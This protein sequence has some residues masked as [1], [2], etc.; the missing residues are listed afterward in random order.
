MSL[1]RARWDEAIC[2]D[3][4]ISWLR[5]SSPCLPCATSAARGRASACRFPTPTGAPAGAGTPTSRPCTRS[6]GKT[7]QAAERLHLLPEGRQGRP[8]PDCAAPTARRSVRSPAP[9]VIDRADPRPRANPA[10]MRT[11]DVLLRRPAPPPASD[12]PFASSARS[13]T[14]A[15]SRCRACVGCP[16]AA[17]A[18]PARSRPSVSRSTGVAVQMPA[19]HQHPSRPEVQQR[20]G[21]LA[22]SVGL[23]VHPRLPVSSS[24]LVEIGRDDRRQRQQPGDVS[25]PA[26]SGASRTSPCLLT[27]TGSTTNGTERRTGPPDLSARP[28]RGQ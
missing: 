19:L 27:P 13:P 1:V 17:H 3:R 26:A 7:P 15:C 9:P 20:L 24:H 5:E 18:A 23:T 12:R 14:P 11:C 2:T 28:R 10:S 22:V 25:R 21:R 6:S 8:R 16:A 4:L